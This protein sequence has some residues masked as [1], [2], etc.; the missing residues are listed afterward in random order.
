[1]REPDALVASRFVTIHGLRMH[2][3]TLRRHEGG[4]PPVVLVH[5]L[6]LS[7]S[8]MMPTARELARRYAV[9]LPDLPGFGDSD[10]P[11][12]A[13]DVEALGDALAAWL[14]AMALGPAILMGN[15]FGCQVIVE[16]AARHPATAAATILQGPTT[17][18]SERNWLMQ[19]VRWRQN[20]RY[21]PPNLSAPTFEAYRKAGYPKIFVTFHY[22]LRHRPEARLP[23]VGCPSLVVR[24]QLDPI[25]R[26]EWAEQVAAALPDGRLVMIPQVAHT[27]CW[28]APV[29]LAA[30]TSAFIAELQHAGRLR[31]AIR[32][33]PRSMA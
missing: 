13:L 28:T 25:C 3:R 17:P 33:A 10:H 16:A 9:Y 4:A 29:E 7:G 24:G 2:A 20:G 18:P 1:M 15:S 22:S 6:G 8:Y 26:Q 27:L 5:G 32:P 23:G 12:H 14:E 31:Q 19:F 21:N 11:P 30:V